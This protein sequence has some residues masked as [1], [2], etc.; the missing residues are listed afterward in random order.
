MIYS[1]EQADRMRDEYAKEHG[2]DYLWVV[3]L[4]TDT[5]VRNNLWETVF[6]QEPLNA[7]DAVHRQLVRLDD[8]ESNA[9]AAKYDGSLSFR[10]HDTVY[11]PV[12]DRSAV[13]IPDGTNNGHSLDE[14]S[15]WH[16]MNDQFALSSASVH[17]AYVRRTSMKDV[18][19][20]FDKNIAALR[21]GRVRRRN[22]Q[23]QENG[24]Q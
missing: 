15:P 9:R 14:A 8:A 20:S 5:M 17:T 11:S 19:D 12:L 23:L 7:R 1:Q 4:R 18:M 22:D 13:H 21:N 3:R 24:D 2:I 10:L 16:G 6:K